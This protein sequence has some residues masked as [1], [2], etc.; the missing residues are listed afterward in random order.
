MKTKLVS[1][2][3]E[4]IKFLEAL[5]EKKELNFT[6]LMRRIIDNYIE[7]YQTKELAKKNSI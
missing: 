5:A 4:Q 1:L 7:A 3:D 6:E 2:P